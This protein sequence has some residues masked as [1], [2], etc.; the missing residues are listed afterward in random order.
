M[1]L[2]LMADRSYE[3]FVTHPLPGQERW[4]RIDPGEAS[5]DVSGS[6][7]PAADATV[8]GFVYVLAL[9][10]DID[11]SPDLQTAIDATIDGGR[12]RVHPPF[13]SDDRTGH[14]VEQIPMQRIPFA[15]HERRSTAGF[16]Q[17]S[18]MRA[19]R[20]IEASSVLANAL[21]IS[22]FQPMT[23][24]DVTAIAIRIINLMRWYTWQWWI[25]R[26]R[27]HT[28]AMLRHALPIN[29]DGQCVGGV[30]SY[31]RLYGRAVIS[32]S[33]DARLFAQIGEALQADHH[34]PESVELM[35]DAMYHHAVGDL[36]RS[37]I[38]AAAAG[39]AMLTEAVA[40]LV[41]SGRLT[42]QEATPIRN[43]TGSGRDFL[44]RLGELEN[45]V[46]SPSSRELRP[47]SVLNRLR[48]A[49]GNVAHAARVDGGLGTYTLADQ[50]AALQATFSLSGWLE[51][52]APRPDARET[53]SGN[54]IERDVQEVR[55][56]PLWPRCLG[57]RSSP[58]S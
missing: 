27:R 26:D 29:A 48:I 3:A 17:F 14:D 47:G 53:I 28:H 35:L 50:F 5:P 10:F 40:R 9:P 41:A 38:D 13:R 46:Q 6:P 42:R 45:L 32:K 55:G 15:S 2:T 58:R 56:L 21:G 54:A 57:D 18:T 7:P 16:R 20:G 23:P 11:V 34:I 44:G 12:V 4:I 37:V 39:D 24:G 51:Q 22:C 31:T 19:A 1:R 52:L 36:R 8:A 33:L 25:G 49:R 30:S 43:P